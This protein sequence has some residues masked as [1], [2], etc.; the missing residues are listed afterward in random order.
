MKYYVSTVMG[1]SEGSYK[2]G[3]GQGSCASPPIW[4]QICS[5]LFDCQNQKSHGANY[6]TPDRQLKFK[7]GMTGF[8]EDTKGQRND[9]T[10]AAPLPLRKLID[11]MQADAQLWGDLLHVLGGASEIPKCN[12]Y[13][14]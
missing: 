1:I 10:E 7:A 4:L 13:V 3:S 9:M 11:C 12:Y 14:M 2:H 5:I 6:C 8:V